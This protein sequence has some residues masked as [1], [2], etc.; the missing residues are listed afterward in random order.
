MSVHFPSSGE[1]RSRIG[2]WETIA[3]QNP[4]AHELV[5]AAEAILDGRETATE[6]LA[7]RSV[8][9]VNRRQKLP[10]G[11][12]WK[13]AEDRCTRVLREVQEVKTQ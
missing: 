6:R 13:R 3:G 1:V 2:T 12:P 7:V 9:Y 8:Q 5:D 4:D 10:H 11:T